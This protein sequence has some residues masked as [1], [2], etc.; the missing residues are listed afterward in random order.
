MQNLIK[1]TLQNEVIKSNGIAEDIEYIY[2]QSNTIIPLK[3]IVEYPKYEQ[4][5]GKNVVDEIIFH[6]LDLQNK[7]NTADRV[8]Y[9]N[10]RFIV[11]EYKKVGGL[12]D[13]TAVSSTH[14][15]GRV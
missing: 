4:K 7:P 5:K 3:A 15:R 12:Y 1:K 10:A 13:V 2:I 6:G 9:D 8:I 14:N 11:T